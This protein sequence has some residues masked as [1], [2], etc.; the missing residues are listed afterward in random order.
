MASSRA[1]SQL[2]TREE[3]GT[4]GIHARKIE[5]IVD[6]LLHAFRPFHD[7]FDELVGVAG[8]LPW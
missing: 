8:E 3:I 1:S 6:Q 4:A 7:E 2:D 5:E